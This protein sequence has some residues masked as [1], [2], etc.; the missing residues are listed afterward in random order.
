MIKISGYQQGRWVSLPNMIVNLRK[1]LFVC[2]FFAKVLCYGLAIKAL[3][4]VNSWYQFNSHKY[5]D[6]LSC[7]LSFLTSVLDCIWLCVLIIF[8]MFHVYIYY[9]FKHEVKC[10]L[11]GL[12][13][14][15][16]GYQQGR[17]GS[18]SHTSVNLRRD[19]FICW[20]YA[21]V[22]RCG[23]AIKALYSVNSWFQFISRKCLD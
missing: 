14:K 2:W 23:L 10:V 19:F 16:Y 1:N 17:R 4:S 6:S 11:C 20:F 8:K 22:R 15:V 13:V 7:S 3:H 5:L 12:E 9:N 18:I 21:K